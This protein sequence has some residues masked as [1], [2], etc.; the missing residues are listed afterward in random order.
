MR[1]IVRLVGVCA[2][3]ASWMVP[4][5][6]HALFSF[7]G[8]AQNLPVSSLTGWTQCYSDTYANS[9]T[10]L[11]TILA[12]CSG[13]QLLLA[14]RP[15]GSSTLTLAANAPR[16]DVI[17]DTGTGINSTHTAN[18]VNWYFNNSWSWG[19]AP[20]GD[21]VQRDSCDIDFSTDSNLRMCWHTGSDTINTGYRCGDN[22]LNGNSR[23]E[24]L[25]FQTSPTPAPA[26]SSPGLIALGAALLAVGAYVTNR[27]RRR[28]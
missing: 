1:R 10:P 28:V 21:S 22:N 20:G 7:I 6:A 8:V 11:S 27:H 5:S 19:F 17:F 25:I 23:W 9:G 14:C 26:L 15:T 18:G 4:L 3:A 2:V 12:Q 24:R 13:A 16:A